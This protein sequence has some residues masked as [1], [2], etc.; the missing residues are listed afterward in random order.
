M[1]D[2]TFT[3][4]SSPGDVI[5]ADFDF[6][7]KL[8]FVAIDKLVDNKFPGT[9]VNVF[10]GNGDGTFHNPLY[11][12]VGTTPG[13]VEV[14]DTNDDALLDIVVL[15]TPGPFQSVGILRGTID[16]L[17]EPVQWHDSG[18]NAAGLSVVDYTGDG[19]ADIGIVNTVGGIGTVTVMLN[20]GSGGFP[21][22]PTRY[23]GA[24]QY[25]AVADFTGDGQLDFAGTGNTNGV[26]L[27]GGVGDGTFQSLGSFS[28][29]GGERNSLAD[30]FNNDGIIDLAV[31]TDP[32]YVG[33]VSVAVGTQD[34]E[35]FQK[36]RTFT[37]IDEAQSLAV[38][39]LNGDGNPDVVQG[40][41]YGSGFWERT[42][43]IHFGI[44]GGDFAEPV[45]LDTGAEAWTVTVGDLNSDGIPDLVTG[46]KVL[47]GNGD[48]S[49]L[50]PINH[51]GKGCYVSLGDFDNDGNEDLGTGGCDQPG[52]VWMVLGNGN[53]TF[54][55]MLKITAGYDPHGMLVHDIDADGFSDLIDWGD[56]HPVDPINIRLS[57][58]DGTFQAP[59][60]LNYGTPYDVKAGDLNGDGS[61]D[62]VV[63]A[64]TFSGDP[65]KIFFGNGDGTFQAPANIQTELDPR[66]STIGDFDNDGDLD[67]A[68]AR[69]DENFPRGAGDVSILRNNGDGTF[70]AP[71]LYVSLPE[72][73]EIISADLDGDNDLELL[74][75]DR[76]SFQPKM[77]VF[78]NSSDGLFAAVRA[79]DFEAKTGALASGDF[80]NDGWRDLAVAQ[81][82]GTGG[83]KVV[84]GN[85]T[86]F[87]EPSATYDAGVFS[88]AV[89][90]TDLN[91]DGQLD[92]ASANSNGTV[93]ILLGVGD[94]TFQPPVSYPAGASAWALAVADFDLD[95]DPD[96][97]V[98]NN[99]AAGTIS[100]LFNNGDGT[101]QAPLWLGV[102]AS[103]QHVVAGDFN[104]DGRPDVAVANFG[105]G[106]VSVILGNGDGQFQTPQHYAVA[107]NL[108]WLAA[109]DVNNDG[110]ADL[111]VTSANGVAVLFNVADWPAPL[112]VGDGPSADRR[113]ALQ[114]L[115]DAA[116]EAPAFCAQVPVSRD[117][118]AMRVEKTEA[119]KSPERN[120][121]IR[122]IGRLAV[123]E[124][125][126]AAFDS[127]S[128]N[129]K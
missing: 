48:G 65:L 114:K 100:F 113:L 126:E 94:G 73:T 84:F 81:T 76:A 23:G 27:H 57:N 99:V 112:P 17:F 56:S 90:A 115:D 93:S 89:L 36:V 77:Y 116:M 60:I 70:Q 51:G 67:I 66:N 32:D 43:Y 29:D 127:L 110:F 78:M 105:G 39:D 44:G 125:A 101:F 82:S 64:T 79:N 72:P 37:S 109:A 9:N 41:G 129:L 16:G 6:D 49:F 10:F 26:R 18:I 120:H 15:K 85:G 123:A 102:G 50:A 30:D 121:A 42:L 34:A 21:P 63:C 106:I 59:I 122:R 19:V 68:I 74:V 53:G 12:V 108:R 52:D 98:A 33:N 45:A 124:T 38:A 87:L 80:N 54:K 95:G 8:D 14:A 28:A 40:S 11:Y 58:G 97:V 71:Q 83:L 119:V 31:S 91:G 62:L 22:S 128:L 20:N 61:A 75:S 88:Q 117:A 25:I 35:L 4:L 46:S 47:F 118:T 3:G 7:N 92:L 13:S 1:S 2:W 24:T 69:W 5:V 104:N 107:Y 55:V 103:P 111:L 86:G 96:L